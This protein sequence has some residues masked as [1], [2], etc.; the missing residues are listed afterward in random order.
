MMRK[1]AG[2]GAGEAMARG[3]TIKAN[4]ARIEQADSW[5]ATMRDILNRLDL[6]EAMG[7]SALAAALNHHGVT[8]PRG[9]L[10]HPATVFR[11]QKRLKAMPLFSNSAAQTLAGATLFL[12][13]VAS[14]FSDETEAFLSLA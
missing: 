9:G 2:I 8:A 12:V 6:S 13:D 11:L 3:K 5:A 4:E 14:R 10:W 1:G 7:A